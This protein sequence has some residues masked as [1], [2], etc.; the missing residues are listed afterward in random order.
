L[1]KKAQRVCEDPVEA[2]AGAELVHIM[3]SDDAAVNALVE[4]VVDAIPKKAIAIDHT[5]VTPQG[6][7]KRFERTERAGSEFL[8][9]PVFQVPQ[10]A[11]EGSGV[12]MVSGPEARFAK[13][14]THL[15]KMCSDLWYLGERRDKAAA[16]KLLAN[17][18]TRFITA[19]LADAHA[20]AVA[21]IS[22]RP[23]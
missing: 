4:R 1:R 20:L 23:T 15:L 19:G 6:T 12:M 8:S 22:K 3:L 11:R 21:S 10:G 5:T 13:V 7:L 16:F 9:A 14:R 17:E 18:I 2:L